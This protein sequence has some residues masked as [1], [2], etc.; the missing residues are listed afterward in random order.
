MLKA[1]QD[2]IKKLGKRGEV[3][4]SMGKIVVGLTLSCCIGQ[5]S[6]MS[7]PTQKDLP[8]APEQELFTKA[9]QLK[10]QAVKELRRARRAGA[11]DRILAGQSMLDKADYD[12]LIVKRQ[13]LIIKLSG[14]DKGAVH[15][16][17]QNQLK[18]V[19]DELFD[20]YETH[21]DV[22]FVER[23]NYL[24]DRKIKDTKIFGGA[25]GVYSQEFYAMAQGSAST[26]VPGHVYAIDYWNRQRPILEN[27]ARRVLALNN[28]GS[29][30]KKL[31]ANIHSR[32]QE[33]INFT[34]SQPIAHNDIDAQLNLALTLPSARGR[35]LQQYLNSVMTNAQGWFVT[36]SG[37]AQRY[38]TRQLDQ[39]EQ[40]ISTYALSNEQFDARLAQLQV[41]EKNL[42]RTAQPNEFMRSLELENKIPY[43]QWTTIESAIIA[44]L[45]QIDPSIMAQI[46]ELIDTAQHLNL[47]FIEK[48]GPI[49]DFFQLLLKGYAPPVKKETKVIDLQESSQNKD[50]KK[51]SN[52]KKIAVKK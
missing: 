4:K 14:A 15:E 24:V 33:I 52:K 19:Q 38:L 41:M 29:E 9:T 17:V 37:E 12:L 35:L 50:V 16:E 23:W 36:D 21:F 11:M 13:K 27:M 44:A 49:I 7:K 51:S 5:V 45:W 30:S 1:G 28:I 8:V 34:S 3:M 40:I 18:T 48:V 43:A 42:A 10:E 46:K 20:F 39:V 26:I 32:L 47:T 2:V 6:S 25:R 22:P 31:S